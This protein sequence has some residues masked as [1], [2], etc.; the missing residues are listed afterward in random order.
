MSLV[1]MELLRI[2]H[3]NALLSRMGCTLIEVSLTFCQAIVYTSR[4]PTADNDLISYLYFGRCS[5]ET[6]S[7]V[8]QSP[9]WGVYLQRDAKFTAVGRIEQERCRLY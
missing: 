9:A 6:E 4:S 8:N 7:N 2:N 1:K 3:F 5:L